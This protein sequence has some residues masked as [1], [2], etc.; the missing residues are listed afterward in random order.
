[1]E[2]ELVQNAPKELV[3]RGG[4]GYAEE[5]SFPGGHFETIEIAGCGQSLGLLKAMFG[6][7][8]LSCS[9][10]QT[11][12]LLGHQVGSALGAGLSRS[13]TTKEDESIL[14][15]LTKR[16]ALRIRDAIRSSPISGYRS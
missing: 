7:Q 6:G 9:D 16:L 1:M 8:A 3:D 15:R 4:A 14:L 10:V 2:H 13:E 12:S 11:C 5:K